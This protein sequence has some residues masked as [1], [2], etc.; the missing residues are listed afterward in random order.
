MIELDGALCA[1]VVPYLLVHG[2]DV[3]LEVT[4]GENVPNLIIY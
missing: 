4:G 2:V 1:L 3:V